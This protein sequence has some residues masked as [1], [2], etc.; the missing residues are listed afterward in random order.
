MKPI[1]LFVLFLLTACTT[2][3][4][5]AEKDSIRVSVRGEVKNPGNF[6]LKPYSTIEDLLKYLKLN[7]NSDLSALNP[8]IVLKD[9]DVLIIE[10]KQSLA[11]ISINTASKEDLETLPGIGPSMAQ[12]IID[13]RN[14]QGLFQRI[15]DIMKVKGIKEKLFEK[16]KDLIR[17]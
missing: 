17:I 10:G 12:K 4:F 2:D 6:E 13:H 5:P 8:N 15:E 11:K 9:G 7:E 1:L 3:F 16:I 14:S